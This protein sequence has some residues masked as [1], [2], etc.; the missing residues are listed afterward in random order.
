MTLRRSD[1]TFLIII[2][3]AIA[4]IIIGSALENRVTAKPGAA[5]LKIATM[6]KP[7]VQHEL[8]AVVTAGRDG[9]YFQIHVPG[10]GK[11]KP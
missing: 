10:E 7:V 11:E 4:S 5:E 9:L 3:F 2:I 8:S 1:L 6:H